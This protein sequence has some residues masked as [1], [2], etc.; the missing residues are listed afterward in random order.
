VSQ[1]EPPFVSLTVRHGST[2]LGAVEAEL[3]KPV[4][5][6]RAQSAIS[7]PLRRQTGRRPRLDLFTGISSPQ[8]KH[9]SEEQNVTGG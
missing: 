5:T 3:A 7:A 2:A 4:C 6:P 9:G 8:E 1:V